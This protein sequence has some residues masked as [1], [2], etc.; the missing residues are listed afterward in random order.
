M[1]TKPNIICPFVALVLAMGSST[2]NSAPGD[3]FEA[4]YCSG[5]IYKFAPDGTRST[6]ATGVSSPDGLAFD[7]SGNLFAGASCCGV[8]FKFAPDGAQT[9]FASGLFT[10]P[11]GLAVDSAGNL[12][13]AEIVNVFSGS[14]NI[15]KFAPDGTRSTFTSE[16]TFPDGLAF[17]G[18]GNLFEADDGTDTIYKFASDGTRST[19]ATGIDNGPAGL[20]FDSTGNLFVS[21]SFTIYKY[22]AGGVQSIFATGLNGAVGL[23]FDSAGN[24]FVADSGTGTIYK[25][26]PDG[27]RT[28]FATGLDC[29]QF[30]A[31]QPAPPTSY[32]AQ[33]QQPINADGTSVFSV[34]RGVIPVK[35]TLT[36]NGV[37]TCTLPPATIAVTRTAGGTIGA[38]D[39]SVYT[40]PADTGSNFRIDGCQYVYNLSAS[41]LGV[42]T[43]RVDIKI[44]NQIVGGATF[45][46]K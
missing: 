31:I 19:F 23:A 44:N 10:H 41:A 32:A 25:F 1:K 21:T 42:G 11:S 34:R 37:A 27:T 12:F 4:D 30:L 40:G 20:A 39:E 13:E 26:A 5:T 46:L 29:P 2:A 9:I 18:A 35:F 15:N 17:D 36:Q 22:T 28:T 38:I 24:L 33:I 43:Y 6:F 7:S 45:A 3:L 16:V 8:I 14:G